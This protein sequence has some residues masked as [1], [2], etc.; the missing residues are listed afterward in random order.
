[1]LQAAKYWADLCQH[2]GRPE[3]AKDPRFE[4]AE[5]LAANAGEAVAILREVFAT[6]TLAEWSARFK[7]LAGQWAP[8]QNTL[9]VA[10]DPQVQANGYMASATTREGTPFELV[11]SPV[12]FDEE[13]TP[14]RRAPEFN[15]HGDD[16]LRELGFDM[17]RIL[18]LKA[19]G[20]VA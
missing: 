12:Q 11:A 18:E 9:E 17:D 8:V 13:P 15:E 2:I 10:A 20:A 7:T 14:T 19:A 4:G 16:I 6:R 1:M 3:L 5:K